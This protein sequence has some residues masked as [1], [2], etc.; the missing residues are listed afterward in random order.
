MSKKALIVVD[1]LNDFCDAK[2]ALYCG[3]DARRI[4]PFIAEKIKDIRSQG[5]VV[6]F[7]KDTHT[8]D[9]KE[10]QMFPP[11]CIEGTWGGEVIPELSPRAQDIIVKKSRYSGFFKTDLEN[12]LSKSGITEVEI[13]GVCTSICVMDTVG[14]L[15]NRFLPV[16][17]WKDG[18]AD[19]DNEAHRFSLKRM[20]K[21][22]GASVV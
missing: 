15:R 8:I 17:V 20:E 2:G 16:T 7:L 6:I 5:G 11:H 18:V 22:Y 14:G 21:I 1:M 3:E 4:I 12:I 10:F 19:F 13:V 9:D